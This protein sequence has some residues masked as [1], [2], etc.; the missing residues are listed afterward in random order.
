MWHE[1]AKMFTWQMFE[2]EFQEPWHGENKFTKKKV[3]TGHSEGFEYSQQSR[4]RGGGLKLYHGWLRMYFRML[5]GQF[6]ALLQMLAP[7]LRRQSKSYQTSPTDWPY[8]P[9][10]VVIVLIIFVLIIDVVHDVCSTPPW[11]ID[12]LV[13]SAIVQ[14]NQPRSLFQVVI[15]SFCVVLVLS[16]QFGKIC[17]SCKLFASIV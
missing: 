3:L 11:L 10:F 13:C 6:D 9:S 12:A 4:D 8:L 2:S 14:K 17:F 15:F 16:R 5:L 1:N 7:R